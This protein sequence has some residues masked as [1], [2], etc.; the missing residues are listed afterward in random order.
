MG[1]LIDID[2]LKGCAIIRPTS[3][4]DIQHIKAC[5]NCISHD[6]IPTA[7]DL[8]KVLKQLKEAET[9]VSNL[10]HYAIHTDDA[11]KIALKGGAE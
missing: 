11:I 3:H 8:E 5:K 6:D 10:G 2:A 9:D 1:R 4:E 7:Y